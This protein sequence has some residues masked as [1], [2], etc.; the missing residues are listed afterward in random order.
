MKMLPSSAYST[1]SP[2]FQAM[3]VTSLFCDGTAT[4]PVF[5]RM[6]HPVP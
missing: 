1:R 6:K 2:I 5:I 3:V 4:V